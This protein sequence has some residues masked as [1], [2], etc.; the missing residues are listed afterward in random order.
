MSFRKFVAPQ[1][2]ALLLLSAVWLAGADNIIVSNDDHQKNLHKYMQV[3][4][5]VMDNYFGDTSLDQL[6]ERSILGLVY[7]M[8]DSTLSLSETPIDT[9][10]SNTNV[11]NLRESY[12]KFEDAYLYVA[13]NHPDV[14]MDKLTE[15]S[16][17]EMLK[18]LDPHS[19]YI[20]PEDSDRIQEEFD[21]KFQGIGIQFNIMQDTITVITPISGG[22]SDQLGIMS[23]DRIISINDT[24]AV[25]Y[26]NED[27]MHRLRGKKGTDVNIE[28]LRPR[29]NNPISFRITRDDIPITT[30]DSYY[31]LDERTGYIKI[32]RFAAT[33]HEEFIAAAKDLK[34]KG[35]NRLMLD[36]RNNPGG[37]LSQAIAISEEF[38]PRGTK[39]V[40][41]ESKHT[42]FNSVVTSQRDGSLKDM[43]VIALVNEGS[44]SASEIVG[45][46]IQDHDRGLVVGRRTFG[47]GLVQQQY[48]LVDNSNIR[49]TIS[50]Y[51]T[52]SGRLI[53][54]PFDGRSEDFAY[55]IDHDDSDFS[56]NSS[57]FKEDI[58]DSLRF[59]TSAGRT[60]Y[61]G[62]GIVPDFI[63]EPDTTSGYVF[64]FMLANRVDFD[65][66]REYL[67]ENGES[68]RDEW[69]DNFEE[70]RN[71]FEWSTE[72]R[73]TFF[74]MMKDRGM[75]IN[76]DL[77][78]PKVEDNNL[79]ISEADYEELSTMNF[80]RMKAEVARQVWGN[81]KFYP[82]I[83]DYFNNSMKEAMTLWEEVSKL[84][85]YAQ[86]AASR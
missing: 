81:E 74:S 27:V 80:G 20:E 62:G 60:V 51:L 23:G 36:M 82:I 67:D 58:P 45:G 21:G 30:L 56:M 63:V 6:Y 73:E 44:A 38:F 83:N 22:P 37:Y 15:R 14:N 8:E 41:T 7:A 5:R 29:N 61:G 46:A 3:Q 53:Q 18:T 64:N 71:D 55:E 75:E 39:L 12:D 84:E 52:P 40:S 66:V 34:A 85:T 35:M 69:E 25:G 78:E 19:V 28:V 86:K 68:F 16:I 11:K 2:I 77:E 13:N 65:F 50:R 32:N 31:M 72:D 76:N 57:E 26:S 54:K 43:G 70:F 79:I 17:K 49:V 24:S 9:T 48:Q 33:T 42:R 59:S 10:F 4:R 1:L 47:K